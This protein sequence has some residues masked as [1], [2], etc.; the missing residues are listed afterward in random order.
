MRQDYRTDVAAHHHD[1]TPAGYLALLS[2]H[3][4]SHAG[5]R[6]HCRDVPVYRRGVQRLVAQRLPVFRNSPF[7]AAPLEIERQIRCYLSHLCFIFGVDALRLHSFGQRP[8][9]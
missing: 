4:C 1:F 3:F 6:G 8:V 5:V 9:H 7:L 2:N